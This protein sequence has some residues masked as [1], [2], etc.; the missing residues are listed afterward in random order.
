MGEML[1]ADCPYNPL[2]LVAGRVRTQQN[3]DLVDQRENPVVYAGER[4]GVLW[5]NYAHTGLR[6][7]RRKVLLRPEDL[8]RWQ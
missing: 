2:T 5:P 1:L 4:V 6:D 3:T 8:R 7:V